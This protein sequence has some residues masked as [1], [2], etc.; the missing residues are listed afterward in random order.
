MTKRTMVLLGFLA[1]AVASRFLILLNPSWANFSPVSSMAL[2]AGAYALN[3]SQAIIW[4]IV[5]IWIS[6]LILNNLVY[7]QYFDG[8]SWGIDIIHLSLFA[9]IALMG[10]RISNL[11]TFMGANVMSVI[12][13]F[14]LSNF[15]VWAGDA[16]GYGF[17]VGNAVVYSKDITGLL[18]CYAAALPFLKNAIISQFFFSA[19][20]FGG[21]ELVK[22]KVLA[23]QH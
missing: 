14:L 6:N 15:A 5:P 20:F 1:L 9:L 13:F 17:H 12:G 11:S 7:P 22:N 16:I 19:V 3:R 4:S 21:F 8:F 10:S 2:F 18:S 23:V